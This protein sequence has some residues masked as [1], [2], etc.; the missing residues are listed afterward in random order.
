MKMESDLVVRAVS[1]IYAHYLEDIS[2]DTVA[3]ELGVSKYTVSRIFTS[4]VKVNFVNYVN[5]LRIDCAKELLTNTSRSIA[6]IGLDSG[7]DCI[8]SFNRI[9]KMHVG[10]SPLQ[11]RKTTH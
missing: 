1:Y 7:F 8:R 4:V 3:K 9:F 2:L 10:M 5:L 6:E 11:Y